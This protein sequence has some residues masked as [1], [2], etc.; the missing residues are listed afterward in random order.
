MLQTFTDAEVVAILNNFLSRLHLLVEHSSFI[1]DTVLSLFH[2]GA[3]QEV[4]VCV[5]MCVSLEW[6]ERGG[7]TE[8]AE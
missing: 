4:G 5:C 2:G 6:R 3:L 7:E 8:D 1:F